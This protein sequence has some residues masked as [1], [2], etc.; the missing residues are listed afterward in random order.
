MDPQPARIQLLV[1]PY[2][3]WRRLL[4]GQ[5]KRQAG[6]SNVDG[7]GNTPVTFYIA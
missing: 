6:S 7:V 4:G 2:Y 3:R 5:F 1:C